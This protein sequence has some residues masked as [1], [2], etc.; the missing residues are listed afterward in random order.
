MSKNWSKV[1]KRAAPSNVFLVLAKR[2]MVLSRSFW[3]L[4]TFLIIISSALVLFLVQL[5]QDL[6]YSNHSLLVLLN[7]LQPNAALSLMQVVAG[8]II[9][10]TSIAFSMT[11]VV[12]TMASQQFGPRLIGNFIED[13]RTQWVLGILTATFVYCLLA[14]RA[15]NTQMGEA[16]MPGL[17]V[18]MGLVL[19]IV[20]VFTLIY[21]IHH[22]AISIQADN[23]IKKVSQQLGT[24]FETLITQ[25]CN[26]FNQGIHLFEPDKCAYNQ[27][28]TS[29]YAG[30]IQGINYEGMA[31]Y[32]KDLSG[33]I[34]L[35]VRTGHHVLCGIA[36]AKIH[37][38]VQ[39]SSSEI[40]LQRFFIMGHERTPMQ[41]PEFRINQLVEM[42]LR[43]LSPGINDPYTAIHCIDSLALRLSQLSNMDLSQALVLDEE[44]HLRVITRQPTFAGLLNC[45]FDQIR[46]HALDHVAVVVRLLEVFAQLLELSKKQS[47]NHEAIM[48]QVQLIETACANLNMSESERQA[49]SCRLNACYESQSEAMKRE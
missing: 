37:S 22:V 14:M 21:F 43:A 25:N 29:E 24:D 15:V 11:L 36:L 3:A 16:F 48:A 34:Q 33:V 10:I 28:V 12:L 27:E 8:S 9:T 1:L 38:D 23:V 2:L 13:R 30:Y 32:A 26:K 19:A 47:A 5:D 35:Q 49:V 7:D 45:A 44:D 31:A 17:T 40:D 6:Q 41:D 18:S 39:L 46:Q 4:P 42:A 20:C